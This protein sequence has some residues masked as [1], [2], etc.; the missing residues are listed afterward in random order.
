MHPALARIENVIRNP[1]KRKASLCLNNGIDKELTSTTIK[2]WIM[3]RPNGVILSRS[4][5]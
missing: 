5:T 4:S 2:A 1:S 3:K